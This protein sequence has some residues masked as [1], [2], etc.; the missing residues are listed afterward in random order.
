MTNT[1]DR[2]LHSRCGAG[3]RW[4]RGISAWSG[5]I[6]SWNSIGESSSSIFRNVATKHRRSPF[7]SETS[8]PKPPSLSPSLAEWEHASMKVNCA[9]AKVYP[10]LELPELRTDVFLGANSRK[11]QVSPKTP[12]IQK[13]PRTS[14]IPKSALQRRGKPFFHKT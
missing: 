1:L 11:P 10:P 8:V 3:N 5:S 4:P 7:V 13:N 12:K 6:L 14:N 2:S 9:S